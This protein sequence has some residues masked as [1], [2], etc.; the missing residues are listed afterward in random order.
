MLGIA[1]LAFEAIHPRFVP[2]AVRL[3]EA[4]HE[5]E[6]RAT[7]T[8]PPFAEYPEL[9]SRVDALFALGLGIAATRAGRL[10]GFL[11][12]YPVA[13]FFGRDNGVYCPLFG[14]GLDP[15]EGSETFDSMYREAA[16]RWVSDGRFTHAITLF[17]HDRPK[18]DGLFWLGFGLRCVDAIKACEEIRASASGLDIVRSDPSL[19]AK[20]EGLHESNRRYYRR[21]P[22]FMP[23]A[24]VDEVAEQAQWLGT[25][26]NA[27]WLALRDG[28]PVGMLRLARE[29]ETYI[30]GHRD[31]RNIKD[32]YVLEEERGRGVGA[33]LLGAAERHL[34]A[35]GLPLCGVDFES[36]NPSA[37]AFWLRHF[38]PY[39][40]SVV[41]R[42]DERIRA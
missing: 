16:A 41:R 15:G 6:R 23:T 18:I 19:F 9:S 26:G 40:F 4:R 10:V 42:V 32:T 29:G 37:T 7:P 25:E 36:L 39:T 11:A 31:M 17:A 38:A 21:S 33:L 22:M 8:I 35:E 5:E 13:E 28:K 27:E 2:E 12:G 14:Q 1:K 34:L 20:A 30:S 3:L 24:E